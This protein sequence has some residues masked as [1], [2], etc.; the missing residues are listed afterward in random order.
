MSAGDSRPWLQARAISA[1][2][3]TRFYTPASSR[4]AHSCPGRNITKMEE[5]KQR[6]VKLALSN[7]QKPHKKPNLWQGWRT[8]EGKKRPEILSSPLSLICSKVH[9]R[10]RG[11]LGKEDGGRGGVI[12]SHET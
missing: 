8:L 9:L 11:V 10:R 6:Q 1:I 2:G 7:I 5:R 12:L 3:D 4:N